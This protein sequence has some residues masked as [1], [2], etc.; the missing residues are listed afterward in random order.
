MNVR[1]D[2]DFTLT[3]FRFFSAPLLLWLAWSGYAN[4]FLF[5]LA[6]TFLSDILDGMAAR[7]LKQQSELGSILDSWAD[8]L[9]YTTITI[10]AWWLWPVVMQREIFFVVIII[11]SY[12]LPVSVGIIKFRAF[13]SYH[14]WLVKIAVALMGLSFFLLF[15]FDL[16]WPFRITA[17]ICL[18]AALEEI[19]ITVYLIE[20]HS[21]VRSLWHVINADSR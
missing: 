6:I 14:T 1:T 15:V 5:L 2:P 16:A 10:S 19:L 13:T 20:I 9:I 17:F 12:L 8:L 4:Y 11:I 18:L 7:L 21:N 3:C